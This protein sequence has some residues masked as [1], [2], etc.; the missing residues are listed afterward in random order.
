MTV[1]PSDRLAYDYEPPIVPELNIPLLRK[2]LEW[3]DSE[4]AKAKRGEQSEWDQTAWCGT[5]CC[6]AGHTALDLGWQH[7]DTTAAVKGDV[8]S[9][10]RDIAK[11]GL[12]LTSCE[13]D[14]LFAG[15]ND[16]DTLWSVAREIT[17][18]E[19]ARL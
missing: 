13:A 15:D 9:G 4:N 11:A 10:V 12:G 8:V 14:L 17:G 7:I 3:A 5:S 19:V 6:I 2:Q 1:H 18:G 16:I